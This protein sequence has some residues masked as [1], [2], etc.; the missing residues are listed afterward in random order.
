MLILTR[1]PGE[2]LYIG[3]EVTVTV[4]GVVGNQVRFGIDAPR[5]I[6]IDRSEIRERR[7]AEQSRQRDQN[8]DIDGNVS[9]DAPE[10]DDEPRPEP[11]PVEPP[12]PAAGCSTWNEGNGPKI[13]TRHGLRARARDENAESAA[14]D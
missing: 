13:L 14:A 8:G 3:D 6:I 4:L 7:L 10:P 11:Q 5:N 2:T 9:P 12:E 1:K